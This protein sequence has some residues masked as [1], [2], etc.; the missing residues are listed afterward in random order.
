[1]NKVIVI[2]KFKDLEH[3]EVIRKIGQVLILDDDRANVL[4]KKGFVEE[5][6]EID[7]TTNS[8]VELKTKKKNEEVKKSKTKK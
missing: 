5:L 2:N 4:I 7:L 6:V 8:E 3:E 1:M